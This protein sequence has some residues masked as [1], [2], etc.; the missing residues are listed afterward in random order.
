MAAAKLKAAEQRRVHER[1]KA[2]EAAEQRR[3]HRAEADEA[4]EQ[5]RAQ[6]KR[7]AENKNR[8][9]LENE[10]EQNRMRKL[11][12]QT[13]REWDAEKKEEDYTQR[14]N[15][16]SAFR[17]GAHG[18]VVDDRSPPHPSAAFDPDGNPS[19]GRGG[20]GRGRGGGYRGGRGGSH[21]ESNI[22]PND[23]MPGGIQQQK[24]TAPVVDAENEFPSLPEKPTTA[25]ATSAISTGMTTGTA[26]ESSS[27]KSPLTPLTPQGSWAE[28]VE[29]SH[30][31]AAEA[32]LPSYQRPEQTTT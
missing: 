18:G 14:N 13:G 16:G 30:N 24:Q 5:R 7:R 23:E 12:A 1:A 26:A 10:R 4:A 17:R 3:A 8:R 19:R 22:K 15:R 28:Q 6:E 27:G 31:A 20:R 29:L 32:D 9:A 21:R 2:D 25:P 11:G